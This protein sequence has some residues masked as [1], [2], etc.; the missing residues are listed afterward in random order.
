MTDAYLGARTRVECDAEYLDAR[1]EAGPEPHYR[2]R[3]QK[4]DELTDGY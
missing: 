1:D 3:E 2:E 4:R